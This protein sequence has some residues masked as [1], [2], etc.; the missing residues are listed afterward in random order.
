MSTEAT[1]STEATIMSTEATTMLTKNNENLFLDKPTESFV[2][3]S[4]Q[5]VEMEVAAVDPGSRVKDV[6]LIR[7]ARRQ[8]AGLGAFCTYYVRV[9]A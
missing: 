2:V 3:C 1:T 4:P 7:E 6:K 9:R 8:D 5:C